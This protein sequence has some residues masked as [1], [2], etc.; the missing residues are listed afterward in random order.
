MDT[1]EI[2]YN[3]RSTD[4]A[5]LSKYFKMESGVSP[6]QYRKENQQLNK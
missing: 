3:L 1:S 6:Q 5:F 4:S 2:A